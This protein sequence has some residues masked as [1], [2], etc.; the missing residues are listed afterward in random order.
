MLAEVGTD[1]SRPHVKT[2]ARHHAARYRVMYQGQGLN[3]RP[4]G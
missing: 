4:V 2:N 1:L 3:L